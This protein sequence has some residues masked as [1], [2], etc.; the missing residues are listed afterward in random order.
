MSDNLFTLAQRA[1]K[2][3]TAY[4]KGI[5]KRKAGQT[6]TINAIIEYGKALLE[7]RRAHAS[8]KMF[9][10]WIEENDLDQTKPFDR[11]QER[12]AAI[13]IAEIVIN[14]SSP[15][16]SIFECNNTWPA[17]IMKWIRTQ[18][19]FE[20][21]LHTPKAAK[22]SKRAKPGRPRKDEPK[23]ILA[24]PAPVGPPKALT[25]EEV[26]PEFVGTP[27][28]WVDKYGHVQV[29]TA[30]QYATAR[31]TA[32]ALH[33]RTLA[34]NGKQL[35][36]LPKVDHNWLR[37]P[38]DL[39]VRKLTEALEYLRPLIAEAEALLERAKSVQDLRQRVSESLQTL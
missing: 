12:S 34:K 32:W 8:H 3:L 26:D 27:M 11:S 31:F 39:D 7:G 13:Q 37:S 33:M 38:K 14:G 10:K 19:W 20:A 1:A 5:T 2:A 6:D 22:P 17:D 23:P 36:E 30:E 15:V 29:M 4:E 24:P 18:S 28:D 21:P 25:R 35:P 16:N 9:N